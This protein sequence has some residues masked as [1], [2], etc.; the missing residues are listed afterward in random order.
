MEFEMQLGDGLNH[1]VR[2]AVTQGSW[3]T[4]I[5]SI[6]NLVDDTSFKNWLNGVFSHLEQMD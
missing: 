1:N 3:S 5:L 4:G 6:E 2:H